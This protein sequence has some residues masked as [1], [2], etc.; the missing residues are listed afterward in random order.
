[1]KRHNLRKLHLTTFRVGFLKRLS[2]Q[3]P[4]KTFLYFPC[5]TFYSY[6]WKSLITSLGIGSLEENYISIYITLMLK[7]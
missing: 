5:F 7:I 3:N 4:P 6:I 1:M 2:A